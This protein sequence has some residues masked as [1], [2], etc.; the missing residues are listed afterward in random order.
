MVCSLLATC[1]FLRGVGKQS[2][3]A[4]Y[5]TT[6]LFNIMSMKVIVYCNF[7]THPDWKL[8]LRGPRL[9]A[10]SDE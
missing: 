10:A 5:G 2:N 7:Q 6:K 9:V 8:C 3:L 4:T 1:V